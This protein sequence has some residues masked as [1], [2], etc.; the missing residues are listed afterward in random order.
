[1]VVA[2]L[3][4][5]GTERVAATI[6]NYWSEKNVNVVIVLLNYGQGIF[7]K[8]C[9]DIT[10]E[11]LSYCKSNK[12]LI[13]VLEFFST[14]F[15]LRKLLCR[16][17]VD[18]LVSFLPHVNII[19]ILAALGIR[20][21]VV[22]SERNDLENQQ[23]SVLWKV[24]RR[25][26]YRLAEAVTVNNR[27]NVS[28]LERFVPSKRIHLL[29]N[30]IN[31]PESNISRSED[32][33]RILAVGRFSKQKGFDVL[34]EACRHMKCLNDGWVVEIVGKGEEEE[35]LREH[36]RR[37]R[38]TDSVFLR[39][40]TESIWERY[41]NSTIL[42]VPSR[43]EGMPNVLLE[44][45]ALGIPPIVTDQVGDLSIALA[46]VCKWIVVPI[47]SVEELA[48]AIDRLAYNP[49]EQLR[50]SHE[51]VKVAVPFKLDHAI[52]SWNSVAGLNL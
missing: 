40:V 48:V 44:G 49:E 27:R 52:I 18:V 45:M 14:I 22:V 28:I 24:M 2:S 5:G 19:S 4:S 10:I 32:V 50:I 47:D 38:L 11:R 8:I 51:I 15:K 36:I 12:Y 43:Y 16:H 46:E 41:I 23:L 25:L 33:R 29:P 26:T 37:Y 30:P 31:L 21:R 7:Y 1:M 42:V 13:Q 35:N 6:A 39:E 3:N 34:I 9:P 17:E 20:C